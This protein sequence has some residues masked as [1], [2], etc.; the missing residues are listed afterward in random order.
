MAVSPISISSAGAYVPAV[1]HT[2]LSLGSILAGDIIHVSRGGYAG[3]VPVLSVSDNLGNTYSRAYYQH[4]P[5]NF[6][7]VDVFVTISVID[8]SLTVS[9][10][11]NITFNQVNIVRVY[12][13][14]DEFN[15]PVPKVYDIDQSSV[16][17]GEF[18]AGVGFNNGFGTGD[19]T[20]ANTL[21]V[22]SMMT[23]SDVSDLTSLTGDTLQNTEEI[24]I[25]GPFEPARVLNVL[26][27]LNTWAE[28]IQ[29]GTVQL[30]YNS[31]QGGI[32]SGLS[33]IVV[34]TFSVPLP[35]PP[36]LRLRG[37]RQ[38]AVRGGAGLENTSGGT[39]AQADWNRPIWVSLPYEVKVGDLLIVDVFVPSNPDTLPPYDEDPFYVTFDDYGPGFP[40][41]PPPYVNDYVQR[42]ISPPTG[43]GAGTGSGYRAIYTC[44]VD[45]IPVQQHPGWQAGGIFQIK[46]RVSGAGSSAVY[47]CTAL[48][49]TAVTV[50]GPPSSM[51]VAGLK[52]LTQVGNNQLMK[53]D[54]INNVPRRALLHAFAAFPPNNVLS[55]MTWAALEDYTI[56]AHWDF[57][58][59]PSQ[60]T[61]RPRICGAA[62][63]D[64]TALVKGDYDA[65]ALAILPTFVTSGGI[66]LIT[67][68]LPEVLLPEYIRRR[69]L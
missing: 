24:P 64:K 29:S 26:D 2:T 61:N 48:G 11:S 53:T 23:A 17:I 69:Y 38:Y 47:Q 31:S 28:D 60:I 49:V 39:D 59:F 45:Y 3:T 56:R 33:S 65:Q 14:V 67:I 9:L 55:S 19:F 12:R 13:F 63:L 68:V 6:Q 40:L 44:M 18:A 57:F 21:V 43:S 7:R 25:A 41:L 35:T 30:K 34:T 15:Q 46:L 51:S 4:G 1:D 42:I 52:S 20:Y 8:G 58:Q 32:G 62:I 66:V 16:A 54:V 36:S 37:G 22:T 50:A 5:G 27:R 10:D